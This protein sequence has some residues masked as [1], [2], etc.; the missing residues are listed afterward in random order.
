MATRDLSRRTF[1]RTAAITGAGFAIVPRH[2]LGR[3]FTLRATC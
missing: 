2:V 1:I 3:G